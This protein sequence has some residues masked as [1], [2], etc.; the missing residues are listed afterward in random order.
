M[1]IFHVYIDWT[2]ECPPR[3]FYVG[4]GLDNRVKLNTRNKHHTNIS[5]K[6]GFKREIIYSSYDESS[7]KQLEIEKI[8]ELHTFVQDPDYNQIGCNYTIGGD[9]GRIAGWHHSEQTKCLIREKRAFQKITPEHREKIS[10][11]FKNRKLTDTH[12]RKLHDH[13]AMLNKTQNAYKNKLRGKLYGVEPATIINLRLM[14]KTLQEI[15]DEYRV[16]KQAI[17][18]F[19]IRNQEHLDQAHEMQ[20]GQ[21]P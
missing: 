6:F 4:K 10:K 17:R 21:P 5:N 7:C 18:Q 14:G 20:V 9:G 13:L 12:R 1:K 16:S 8:K 19:L 15:A 2:L 11:F 3:P